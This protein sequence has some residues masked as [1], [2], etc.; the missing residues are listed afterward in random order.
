[1]A[2]RSLNVHVC[3][4]LWLVSYGYYG[5]NLHSLVNKGVDLAVPVEAIQLQ[6]RTILSILSA[7]LFRYK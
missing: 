1:M 6:I 5:L 2:Y 4:T 3:S 7:V